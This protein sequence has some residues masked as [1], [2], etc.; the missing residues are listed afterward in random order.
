[1]N[2]G[3]DIRRIAVLSHDSLGNYVVLTP[4][5]RMLREAY[6]EASLEYVGGRRTEALWRVEPTWNATWRYEDAPAEAYDLVVSTERDEYAV[7]VA[8]RI[9][10]PDGR[11]VGSGAPD[12]TGLAAD[13]DWTASDLRARYPELTTGFIAEIHARCAGLTGPVPGYELP[14]SEA[15]SHGCRVLVSCSASTDD[16]LWPVEKWLDALAG[17]AGVGVVGVKPKP[18]APAYRGQDE[19]EA[20]VRSGIGKDL[21]GEFSLPEL[22]GAV[23][24]AT[25]V[26]TI[27]NGI[28]H[29]A[30]ATK[31]PIVALFREGIHRL[32]T[33][34]HADVT[35]LTPAPG[36]RVATIP[37]ETVR[38]AARF[39]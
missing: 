20:I 19:E 25:L 1:M 13:A 3:A 31:T 12:A 18:D 9:V 39:G 32:W 29:L 34:P 7:A 17:V 5:M 38:E 30:A 4:V 26:L 27:D 15:P 2:E 23:E 36:E 6:P 28:M 35:V 8:K 22:V 21:R 14:H 11:I 37:V 16:K 10:A 33:P 24:E